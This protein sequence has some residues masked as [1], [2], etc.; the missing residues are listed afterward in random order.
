MEFSLA[1]AKSFAAL[2]VTSAPTSR[3]PSSAPPAAGHPGQ[4]CLATPPP[5]CYQSTVAG[6][7]PPGADV[8][9]A[10]RPSA[11]SISASLQA[12]LARG[13]LSCCVHLAV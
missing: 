13:V 3:G 6:T 10:H 5:H 12:A 4:V 9:E 8:P 11:I 2:Q 7:P 1:A